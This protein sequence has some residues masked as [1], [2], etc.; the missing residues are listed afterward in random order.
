MSVRSQ[1]LAKA[2]MR[3]RDPEPEATD[4]KLS[5]QRHCGWWGNLARR[6]ES[7]LE[8]QEKTEYRKDRQKDTTYGS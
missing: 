7:M 2:D 8:L 6:S 5:T 4:A 1:G 3:H